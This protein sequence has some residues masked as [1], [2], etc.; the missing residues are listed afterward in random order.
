MPTRY[1]GPILERLIEQLSR[2]RQTARDLERER[3]GTL[4]LIPPAYQQSARNLLHYL[5]LRRFDL[6]PVQFELTGL[7]LSSLGR[8]ESH[9]LQSLDAV[10]AALHR[11][12]DRAWSLDEPSTPPFD[13]DASRGALRVAAERLLGPEPAD[14]GVRIM[15]TMPA[16]AAVDPGIVRDLM[17]AGM[18]VARINAAHDDRG[19]WERIAVHVRRAEA[20]TGRPCRI[21]FDLGGPKLRT[22]SL[23]EG[24]RVVRV[25]PRRDARGEVVEPSLVWIAAIGAEAPEGAI[26]VSGTVVHDARVGDE[27]VVTDASGGRRKLQVVGRSDG[28]AVAECRR[29][30]RFE[31]GRAARLRRDGVTIERGEIG[32][33]PAIDRAITVLPDDELWIVREDVPPRPPERRADGVLARPAIVPTTLGDAL[34]Q[35][36]VGESIRFDDGKIGGV[37]EELLPDGI[38]VRIRQVPPGGAKLRGDKGVNLPDSDLAIPCPTPQDLRDLE[39]ATEHA[40]MVGMSFV[41]RPAD[42]L[43]LEDELTSRGAQHLG[44]VLKIET[45]RAFQN[46]PALL[47]AGL[48]SPP[49]GVMVARGDLAVEVGFAR[50]AEVQE[51]ILWLCEAAHVPVIWA[52]Q[53]LESLAKNGLPSR[54]EVSDAAMGVQAECVMLNKGP[55][56]TEAVRLLADV[57]QRMRAHHQKKRAMLRPLSVSWMDSGDGE[58]RG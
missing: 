18:D 8:A 2:V 58:D 37:V 24:P 14:R 50:L 53:V 46:L 42:L 33:L 35:V 7:G 9:V 40:D 17:N 21:L 30:V 16:D 13:L 22:C 56:V 6:R 11:L 48:R 57:L 49:I 32:P 27:I 38:R 26:P 43:R 55:F 15:V 41:Q 31:A 36:R 20:E 44:I 10:L 23:G 5:A 39:F 19:V 3:A 45:R 34:R 4:D 29:T 1:Q 54:A 52:T 47:L 12:G 25:K 28:V 51:E